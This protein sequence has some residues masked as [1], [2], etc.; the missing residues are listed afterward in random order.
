MT[1][2]LATFRA[3]L[4]AFVAALPPARRAI[5]LATG[6]GSTALVLGLAWWVQRPLYRPLFTNLA[7]GDAAA[8]VAALK[9][10]KVDY[11]LDDDGHAVLVPQGELY[12]E[13]LALASRGLP[14]GSGVGFEIFDRQQLGQTDFLQH[15]N[16]QRA[17][18]GEL[19]RTIAELG[20]VESAR[21]HLAIPE[22]SLFVSQDRRP[23]ASV[24]VKLAAGRTLARAQIDG[25]VHLVASSVQGL[26]PEAVT[27]L[28]EGG[29]LLTAPQSGD[30][31]LATQ[32]AAID[33]QRAI[34]RA[35]EERIES[36]VATVVGPG[37]VIARVAASLDF[38]RT[39]R[40]EETVDPDRTAV[41]TSHTT[42]EDPGG[43][44]AAPGTSGAQRRDE[45]QEYEVSRTKVLTVAPVG[46][47]K[48]L[49]VAVLVD[50]SYREENG[51]RVFVARTEDELGKLR[52]L[53]ASAV[54]L[55][56]TRG[57][58]L[59]LTSAPFQ[60]PETPAEP[61]PGALGRAMEWLPA[62]LGR[63]FGAGVVIA[64]LALVVRPLVAAL[65]SAGATA[66]GLRPGGPVPDG[67]AAVSDLARENLAL[68]QQHPERAAQLVRQWLLDS[69]RAA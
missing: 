59:E 9:A 24:V 45:Q 41:K 4:G 8:I 29:R 23:S 15:L 19:G 51:R 65:G 47:V 34:E 6:I 11:A 22:R 50:G 32:G 67:E 61:E 57:D 16:Y 12:E 21:V 66:R 28:D 3:N 10:D 17:L 5:L 43:A 20:G 60:A 37:K 36:L 53:V 25:I 64:L 30:P 42:R 40:T 55:D 54:G 38:S 1:A 7:S 31:A 62:L 46:S 2:R 13:R 49:S 14:E 69:Q 44:K 58:R 56:E 35:T 52:T 39:E 26:A 18:Q 48:S 68:V 27:V 33:Y 63:L